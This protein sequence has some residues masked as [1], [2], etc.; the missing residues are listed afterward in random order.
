MEEINDIDEIVDFLHENYFGTDDIYSGLPDRKINVEVR[1]PFEKP[2]F[3]EK[4]PDKVNIVFKN[5]IFKN[6]LKLNDSESLLNFENCKFYGKVMGNGAHFSGKI[7]FRNCHFHNEVRFKNTRFNDLADFYSC[8]FYQ[9]TIFYKTDFLQTAVFSGAT[10]YENVLFTYT[11]FNKLVIFR[12]TNFIKGLDLSLSILSGS[13][14]V[15]DIQLKDFA[16]LINN[17][18]TD[19]Y[20]ENVF[21]IGEIP[22]KNKRETF[23][24]LRKTFEGNLDYIHSLDYKKLELKT[25]DKILDFNIKIGKDRWSNKFNKIILW[26]NRKSNDYGTRFE[27][28]V[29]F[30]FVI[31]LI[32][33]FLT[34]ISTEVFWNNICF[35]CEIDWNVIGYTVKQFVNYLN[36]VHSIDFID[37]LRPFFGISYILDF[38]GRIAVGYGIYQTIQAFR[39]YR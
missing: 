14:S 4:T 20:E 3:P 22:I 10:F 11:L 8:H 38:F 32:F 1:F 13:L 37:E 15:F 16:V 21:V 7:R 23:R 24:I 6:E 28:G 5:C 34:F 9:R 18:T 12:G 39:K 25:Y 36:P 29:L 33:F 19:E 27:Y 17:P 2:L 35:D 30:T 31:G 26:L